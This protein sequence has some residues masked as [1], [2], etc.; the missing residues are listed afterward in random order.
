MIPNSDSNC[1]SRFL[2]LEKNFESTFGVTFFSHTLPFIKNWPYYFA[3]TPSLL[4][5]STFPRV[6]EI[7]ARSC[8]GRLVT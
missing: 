7:Y 1:R 5:G 8:T 2:G 4:L 3:K 6:Q